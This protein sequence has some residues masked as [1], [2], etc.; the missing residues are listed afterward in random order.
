MPVRARHCNSTPNRFSDGN[1]GDGRKLF[2]GWVVVFQSGDNDNDDHDNND[3][4]Y[5][6]SSI[7]FDDGDGGDGKTSSEDK[8]YSGNGD[9]P[10]TQ[11]D[12]YGD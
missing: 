7:R 6:H 3:K 9:K 2:S 11:N 4:D 10:W 5:Q 12:D 1:T 8:L